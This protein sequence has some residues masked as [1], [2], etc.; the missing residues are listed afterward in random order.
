MS[1][2]SVGGQP[3]QVQTAYGNGNQSQA[4]ASSAAGAGKSHLGN[5][6][7]SLSTGSASAGGNASGANG[8]SGS[9]MTSQQGQ[10]LKSFEQSQ[11][12]NLAKTTNSPSADVGK[13]AV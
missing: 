11:K 9:P 13:G 8:A 4:G 2:N 10:M 12:Q 5:D 7:I 1:I 3:S 6:S